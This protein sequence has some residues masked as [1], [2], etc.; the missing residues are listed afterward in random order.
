VR[1]R[2]WIAACVQYSYASAPAAGCAAGA[3][4]YIQT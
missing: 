4:Q 1:L 2:D 3:I